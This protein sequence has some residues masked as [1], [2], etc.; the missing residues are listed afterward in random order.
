MGAW[1]HCLEQGLSHTGK[2]R[3]PLCP[4]RRD[5]PQRTQER[6]STMTGTSLFMP[7][8][9]EAIKE[10]S[11]NVVGEVSADLLACAE[12]INGTYGEHS[13]N[14]SL[15]HEK[16]A[17]SLYWVAVEVERMHR[18]RN[19]DLLECAGNILEHLAAETNTNDDLEEE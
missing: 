19:Y 14:K 12:E 13:D 17:S 3:K 15:A 11:P 18:D 5:S 8:T 10:L 4:A 2:E 1:Y 16:A 7:Q 9:I 6:T